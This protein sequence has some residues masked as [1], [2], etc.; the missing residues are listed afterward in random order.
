MG[1]PGRVRQLL[2]EG[3]LLPDGIRT[4]VIDEADALMVWRRTVWCLVG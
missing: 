3:S 2:E 4:F 1:T